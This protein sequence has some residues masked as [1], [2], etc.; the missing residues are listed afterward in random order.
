MSGGLRA[1]DTIKLIMQIVFL[2]DFSVSK[3]SL[4]TWVAETIVK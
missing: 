1:G 3:T 2:L 4:Q